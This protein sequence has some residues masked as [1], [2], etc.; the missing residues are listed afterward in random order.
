MENAMRVGRLALLLV[1]ATGTAAPAAVAQ[2]PTSGARVA[3]VYGPE[4]VEQRPMLR[5]APQFRYPERLRASRVQG[6]VWLEFVV[7]PDGKVDS[8][9]VAVVSSPDPRLDDEAK[10]RVVLL[11]FYPGQ[12]GGE[13]VA[14][15]VRM[16]I[17]FRLRDR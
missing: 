2:A 13:A 4:D 7:K 8:A 11:T 1:V 5:N 9:S 3:M 15:R 16:P 10:R 14:V 6:D 17:N 12:V